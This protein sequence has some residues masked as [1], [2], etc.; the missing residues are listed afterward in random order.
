MLR[1]ALKHGLEATV[2]LILAI[3]ALFGLGAA[4]LSQGPI[5]ADFLKPMIIGGLERQVKGGQAQLGHVGIVW[6]DQAKSLGVQMENLSVTD[7]KGRQ[8]LRAGRVQAAMALDS[9]LVFAP[10]PGH[11]AASDFFLA[12]SVSPQGR[13]E[14]GYEALGRPEELTLLGRLFSEVTGPARRGRWA[15]FLHDVELTDGTLSLRQ[16]GGPVSWSGDVRQLSLRKAL[17]RIDLVGNV[18]LGEGDQRAELSIKAKAAEGLKEA[19]ISGKIGRLNPARIFPSVGITR[20]ISALNA[21]VDGQGS[22]SYALDQGIQAADVSFSAGAGQI[23]FGKAQQRFDR[24]EARATYDPATGE[25][26]LAS[27]KLKAAPLQLDIKG[28]LRLIPEGRDKQPARLDFDLKGPQAVMAFVPG[29]EP[30]TLQNLYVKGGYTPEAGHLN[31]AMAGAVLAGAKVTASGDL[32]QALG[33]DGLPQGAWGAKLK[34]QID[35]KAQV[36]QA[37]PFWPDTIGKGARKWVKAA[38]KQGTLSNV[39][40]TVDIPTGTTRRGLTNDMLKVGFDF[41]GVTIVIVPGLPPIEQGRGK[42]MV[43]GDRFDLTVASGVMEGV[44]LSEGVVSYPRFRPAAA[45]LFKGRARGPADKILDIL[46]RKPLRLL[47]RSPFKAE[48]FSGDADVSF[49][50]TRPTTKVVLAKDYGYQF[51]GTVTNGGIDKVALGLDLQQGVVKVSGDNRGLSASGLA[52]VGIFNGNIDF[53]LPFTNPT[54]A[55]SR[56]ALDGD[57]SLDAHNPVPTTGQF[58]LDRFGGRGRFDSKAASGKVAWTLGEAGRVTIDGQVAAGGLRRYGLPVSVKAAAFDLSAVLDRKGNEWR[59]PVTAGALAGD[60]R[61]LTADQLGVDFTAKL[62]RAAATVL[63]LGDM[64]LFATAQPLAVN[65]RLTKQD[66]DA[67]IALG[68]LAGRLGWVRRQ[69]GQLVYQGRSTLSQADLRGLGAPAFIK[70]AQPVTIEGQWVAEIEGLSGDVTV[71]GAPIRFD[72]LQSGPGHQSVEVSARLT[73]DAAVRLGLLAPG[74]LTGEVPLTARLEF[75]ER[76]LISGHAEADMTTAQLSLAGTDWSKPANEAATL[77]ADFVG[78][79]DDVIALSTVRAEGPSM[80]ALV[81]GTIRKGRLVSLST[82]R[83]RLKGLFDGQVSYDR[84]DSGTSVAVKADYLDARRLLHELQAIDLTVPEA[85]QGDGAGPIR[86]DIAVD[87]VKVTQAEPLSDLRL[88]ADWDK[89]LR[90]RLEASVKGPGDAAISLAIAPK[91][92][93]VVVSGRVESVGQMVESVSG[94]T[95]LKGGSAQLSGNLVPGGAD[96]LLSAQSV[97]VAR[98]PVL[99]QILTLGAFSGVA[100]TL[101]GEGIQFSDVSSR[102]ALRG[103]TLEIT[104]ARATGDALGLTTHGYIDLSRQEL[105]LSGAMA[106]AYALNSAVG[107]IPVLGALM[108]S[109]QGEGIFGLTYSAKGAIK[110]PRVFVNPLSLATPGMLRRVFDGV[111]LGKAV[112]KAPTPKPEP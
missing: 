20:P 89:G 31:F 111:P 2:V 82:A 83:A 74:E 81:S 26:E 80:E 57:I 84:D 94:F 41:D 37:Y 48:D 39:K 47:A 64:P 106:P 32:M 99:A 90:R 96:L 46:D 108:I 86:L 25:V 38:L 88:S 75:E 8:V 34:A 105:D 56:L 10:A 112:F 97:R 92:D 76:G 68:A 66:G 60:L 72:S 51:A 77:K 19:F 67:N 17:G 29:S 18:S 11:I 101:N 13:Y 62:D 6:F 103:K 78:K 58:T 53:Q 36:D 24:A 71:A 110:A 45:G 33:K 55:P 109:R 23:R 27:V 5:A 100:N 98:V 16:I 9:V 21:Q 102:M 52:K 70:P 54:G 69:D 73:G 65:A 12:V 14:L 63:G 15:S 3:I 91:D 42:A 59:G 49:T 35:G 43:Q 95:N 87:R 79:E 85:W 61:L 104:E 7:Q 107:K 28:R 44:Q 1:P 93:Q 40:L 50:I 4:R 22:L 30:Q